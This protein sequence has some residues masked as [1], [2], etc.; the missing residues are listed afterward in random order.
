MPPAIRRTSSLARPAEPPQPEAK[1]A[2]PRSVGDE[3]AP[4]VPK[5]MAQALRTPPRRPAPAPDP[6]APPFGRSAWPPPIAAGYFAMLDWAAE[7][8]EPLPEDEK[9][10]I[11]LFMGWIPHPGTGP[12]APGEE[13]FPAPQR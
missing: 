2:L 10:A 11:H 3:A 4:R 9:L 5:A 7:G 13:A 1:R 8:G 6:D 12:A